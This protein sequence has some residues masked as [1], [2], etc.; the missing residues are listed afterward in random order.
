MVPVMAEN[1]ARK[2]ATLLEDMADNIAV[3]A[4]AMYRSEPSDMAINPFTIA[5]YYQPAIQFFNGLALGLLKQGKSEEDTRKIMNS[6]AARWE[7]E[8][9]KDTFNVLGELCSESLK[10]IEID[11]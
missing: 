7:I 2:S 6:K 3:D 9:L 4:Y 8:N 5:C 1:I 10:D 11:Y